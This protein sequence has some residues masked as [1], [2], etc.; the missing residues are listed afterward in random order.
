MVERVKE[1]GV[2]SRVK[3]V[4]G[5]KGLRCSRDTV[6]GTVRGKEGTG[7]RVR[8]GSDVKCKKAMQQ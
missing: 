2:Q 7:V 6:R 8:R 1:S 4:R 3:R 5:E